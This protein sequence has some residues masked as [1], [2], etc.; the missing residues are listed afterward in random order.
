MVLLIRSRILG[1]RTP[2]GCSCGSQ[3][4]VALVRQKTEGRVGW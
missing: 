2:L 3:G 1:T 4:P